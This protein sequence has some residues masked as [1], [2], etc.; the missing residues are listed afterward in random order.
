MTQTEYQLTTPGDCTSTHR[1]LVDIANISFNVHTGACSLSVSLHLCSSSLYSHSSTGSSFRHHHSGM[2]APA[3]ASSSAAAAASSI[4]C[5]CR[6]GSSC[7]PSCRCTAQISA[8]PN[9]QQRDEKRHVRI[10]PGE[11]L[12]QISQLRMTPLTVTTVPP[13]MT[14]SKGRIRMSKKSMICSPIMLIHLV[15]PLPTPRIPS[16]L[17]FRSAR[18]VVRLVSVSV[19]QPLKC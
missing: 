16:L 17:R 5:S 10:F 14:P 7:G 13:A 6:W 8:T 9:T 4:R 12:S 11:S 1:R 3:A 18:V 19:S 15:T 2:S